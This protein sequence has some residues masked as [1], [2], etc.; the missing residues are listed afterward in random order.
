M[1]FINKL[2]LALIT[3][4]L[5]SLVFLVF[6]ILYL[7]RKRKLHSPSATADI[8]HQPIPPSSK[9]ILY[10]FCWKNHHQANRIEP[11]AATVPASPPPPTAA[12]PIEEEFEEMVKLHELYGPSRTLFTI[13]EETELE[14]EQGSFRE[15]AVVL[16]DGLT[17]TV[18]EEVVIEVDDDDDEVTAFSTPCGSPPYYTPSPSPPRE[19]NGASFRDKVAGR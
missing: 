10:F 11:A 17:V 5:I 3:I 2:G 14:N 6:Q 7:W 1:N 8:R 12:A 19:E 16:K 13:K 15:N 9:E 4:F 18:T